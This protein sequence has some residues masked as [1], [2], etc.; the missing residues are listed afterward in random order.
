MSNNENRILLMMR[1]DGKGVIFIH[2]Y[3]KEQ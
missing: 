3:L 1:P 2:R